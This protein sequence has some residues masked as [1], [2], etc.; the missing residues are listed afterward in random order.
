MLA[1]ARD[2]RV[3]KVVAVAAPTDMIGLY[4]L[5]PDQFKMLFF[6]DLVNGKITESEA[7]L[8]FIASSPIHFLEYMPQL[9]LHHDE[10]DP[11]V[12]VAFSRNFEKEMKQKNKQ[13]TLYVYNEGIH[14]FWDD[15]NF[16][17][18]VQQFVMEP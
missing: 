16:W 11:F 1:A 8:S 13:L 12:P 17:N 10:G 14:G 2:K 15:P 3:R 9:Q 7:R 18:R 5:Y 4:H 6:N